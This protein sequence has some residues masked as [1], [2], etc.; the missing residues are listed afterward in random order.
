MEFCLSAP[1]LGD[2]AMAKVAVLITDLFEDSEYIV[3]VEAFKKEG[4]EIIHVGLESGKAVQGKKHGTKVI[5][6]TT[7]RKHTAESFDALLIPGGYSPDKLRVDD[8]AVD[9]VRQFMAAEKPVFSICHGPQILITAKALKGRKVTGW[10]SIIQ[11]IINA[12]ADF[13]DAEVV[14]DQ[15]LVSS[16]SPMDLQAFTEACL[17]KLSN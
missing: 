12:G 7:P 2:I 9:F 15:N 4:H 13:V 17:Q 16:R 5:I 10:K 1:L 11:D 8:K 3:P 14:V 6:D